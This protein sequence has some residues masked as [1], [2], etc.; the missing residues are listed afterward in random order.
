MLLLVRANTPGCPHNHHLLLLLLLSSH[1]CDSS[2]KN[3]NTHHHDTP[4]VMCGC[5]ACVL[6]AYPAPHMNRTHTDLPHQWALTDLQCSVVFNVKHIVN[7]QRTH[8]QNIENTQSTH[9]EHT[10]KKQQY[11]V[12]MGPCA[13]AHT[14]TGLHHA[15]TH[16]PKTHHPLHVL[17]FFLRA[18]FSHTLTI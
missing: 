10:V 18:V 4:T 16:L 1:N 7:T 6:V 12:C 8:S 15:Y 14:Q 9:R 2:R 11:T 5:V 13:C 17:V 3:Y